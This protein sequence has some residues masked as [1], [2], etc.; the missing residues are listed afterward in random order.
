MNQNALY[1][2]SYGLFVLTA[3]GSEKES[4]CIINTTGQVTSDPCQITIAI[5]KGNFTTELIEQSKEFNVSILDTSVPFPLFQ[6]FGFQSGRDADK[7]GSCPFPLEKGENGIS[8]L[9]EHSKAYLGCK[10]VNQVDLGSHI[11]FVAKVTEAEVLSD[12]EAVTYAY[13][14]A[15][16]KPQPS[17]EKKAGWHCS[18]CGYVYEGEELPE[19]FV[20]PICKHPASD[21]VKNA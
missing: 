18:I 19:D 7:I 5:N 13:Y 9:K 17:K 8:Y 1:A 14:H 2:L 16:I 3:K 21:F 12:K 15:N 11:L 4:G 10:V 6:H 20:C